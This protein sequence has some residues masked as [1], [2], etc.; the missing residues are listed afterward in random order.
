MAFECCRKLLFYSINSAIVIHYRITPKHPAAHLFEV[1]MTIATPDPNGQ[2]L[3]LPVWIPGSYMVREF[4]RNLSRVS[5]YAGGHAIACEKID[6]ATWQC[7]PVD[8]PI[9]VTYEV[10]AWDLSVRAAHL[11][12]THGFFNGTSV[13]LFA[14]SFRDSP[15]EVEIVRPTGE[16]FTDWRIATSLTVKP[17]YP[18]A[19][20]AENASNGMPVKDFG[21]FTADS[22]DD[23][24]DHPVEMGTFTHASF[25]ACGVTHH[26]AIT[27]RYRADVPR[28]CADFKLFC[29]AQIRLF[30]PH[31]AAA[32]MAEYWFLI[33]VLGEG[34]GG[35]E[36]RASTALIVSRD[37]LPLANE[38][39][40][41]AGYRKLLSLAS[42]EYFHT[43]NVK[44]ILPAAFTPYPLDRE[45]YTTQ[46][47]FF[48]GITDY[49]DDLMLTRAGLITP[50]EYLEVEA[51]NIGRVMGQ[52]GRT[53]QT[54]AESSFDAWIKYYRQDENAV[55]SIVSYYQKGAI[56]G[57]ALD[58]TIREKTANTKSLDDVMRALWQRH[59]KLG[60]AVPE[61][62]IEKTASE[63]AGVDLSDF[64]SEAVYSVADIDLAKLFATVG[65]TLTWRPNG[66][67]IAAP[68]M[69]ERTLPALG[70]KVVSDSNGDAKL[71]QV[72][73]GGTAMTAGLSAGDTILAVDGLR[74]NAATLERR[75]KSYDVGSA[76]AIIACRRD[77]V[78]HVTLTLQAQTVMTCVLTVADVPATAKARR[79][80][81]LTGTETV[82]TS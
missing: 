64:F 50:L 38:P 15:C 13:F 11:D 80:S 7:A 76:L 74:V 56:I 40:V 71:S 67:S 57:L 47:W 68:K 37:D 60:V 82:V 66:A 51:E 28:L 19:F 5:A 2:R 42:H 54:V 24:I 53:R 10:Y 62:D 77:E 4:A 34:F 26:I 39:R 78:F 65:V 75:I 49:Y 81:W 17:K 27:G 45:A 61:G 31:T 20:S 9:S 21:I 18:R 55:N 44:R 1:T 58:L 48:E 8:E 6:K 63:I 46:L 29:E 14:E 30:E 69:A 43:W 70:A 36:H 79:L 22:Y 3:S 32:P 73:T 41:T 52:H 33:T 23:L 59:G 16:K 12:E 72:F 35:L 25:E